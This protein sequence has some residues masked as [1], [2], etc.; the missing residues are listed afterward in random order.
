MSSFIVRNETQPRAINGQPHH[1]TTGVPRTTSAQSAPRSPNT[2]RTPAQPRNGPIVR[3]RSGSVITTPTRN[4]RVKSTSSGLGP[5]SAIAPDSSSRPMPQIGQDPGCVCRTDGCIGQVWT[6]PLARQ[7]RS[8]MPI[9]AS[10]FSSSCMG[11]RQPARWPSR[12][13]RT[14]G[15]A[16]KRSQEPG[17]TPPLLHH[18]TEKSYRLVTSRR[19]R[20]DSSF[21]VQNVTSRCLSM[22]SARLTPPVG[23]RRSIATPRGEARTHTLCPGP[24]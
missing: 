14:E 11:P 2:S 6:T 3:T 24:G 19:N 21:R 9:R 4:R 13:V 8:I 22:N 16:R 1:N 15:V 12:C 5:A 10:R 18:L 23:R 7:A 20:V 17:S